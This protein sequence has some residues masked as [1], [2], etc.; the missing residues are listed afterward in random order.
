[1]DNR[2]HKDIVNECIVNMMI[3]HIAIPQEIKDELLR[4]GALLAEQYVLPTTQVTGE[5]IES[6]FRERLVKEESTASRERN[7]RRTVGSYAKENQLTAR[8]IKSLEEREADHAETCDGSFLIE[9]VLKKKSEKLIPLFFGVIHAFNARPRI[10]YFSLNEA[11]E[12]VIKVCESS[13]KVWV[14]TERHFSVKGLSYQAGDPKMFT[15][16]QWDEFIAS[17]KNKI[18][19]YTIFPLEGE[20]QVEVSYA[21]V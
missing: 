11:A 9:G 20:D 19:V 13:K 14:S 21:L 1:M 17:T 3:S 5:A 4:D 15:S 6:I 8:F 16:Q 10:N 2:E 18:V 12:H 7:F